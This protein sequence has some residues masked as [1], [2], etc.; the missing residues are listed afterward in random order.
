ML[1]IIKKF[2]QNAA[3]MANPIQQGLKPFNQ[4]DKLRVVMLAAMANPIQQG[5]KLSWAAPVDTFNRA[6]MANPIQQGL[7]P[8]VADTAAITIGPQWLIQYNKD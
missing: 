5:L 1:L 4:P 3:A 2:F 6:A 8:Q 7:K